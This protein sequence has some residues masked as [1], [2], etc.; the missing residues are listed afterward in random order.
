MLFLHRH[1]RGVCKLGVK[2]PNFNKTNNIVYQMQEVMVLKEKPCDNTSPPVYTNE[3]VSCF[4]YST[5]QENSYMG[6][7]KK[8]N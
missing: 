1:R 5:S 6:V 7:M 4:E 3:Y 2:I 8:Q